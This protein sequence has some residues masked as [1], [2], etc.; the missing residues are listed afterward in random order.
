MKNTATTLDGLAVG[1]LGDVAA[2]SV[3]ITSV[4]VVKSTRQEVN[5]F[6]TQNF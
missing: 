6:T 4:C 2:V 5:R 1:C 3:Q